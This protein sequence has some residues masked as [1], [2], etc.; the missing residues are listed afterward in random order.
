M[1]AHGFGVVL[2][3]GYT[4]NKEYFKRLL[5]DFGKIMKI[6]VLYAAVTEGYIVEITEHL[7]IVTVNFVSA[8]HP[9]QR[10][11]KT[12]D[13]IAVCFLH[14]RCTVN[15][16]RKCGH[17]PVCPFHGN[18]DGLFCGFQKCL[19]EKMQRNKTGV[20]LRHMAD[21]DFHT[22]KIHCITSLL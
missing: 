19:I 10:L 17:F 7:L 14:V 9:Q 11:D 3:F 15:K 12:A 2:A 6:K 18:A 5:K 1:T 20:K 22:E 21:V 13:V 8:F 16:S 4:V